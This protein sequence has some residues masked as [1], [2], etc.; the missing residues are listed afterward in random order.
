MIY[1]SENDDKNFL[2]NKKVLEDTL[3]LNSSVISY[4]PSSIKEDTR[5]FK[6][7]QLVVTYT[8]KGDS[9]RTRLNC[10]YKINIKD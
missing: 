6:H 7:T 8:Y 4:E 2:K 5:K 1:K 9:F 3:P 10:M